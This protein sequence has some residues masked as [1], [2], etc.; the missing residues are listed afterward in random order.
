MEIHVQD[1][2]RRWLRA[3]L[4]LGAFVL[5]L[6]L[7]GQVATILV[8]FSDIL[9]VLLLAWLFAFMISPLVSLILRAAPRLPR[10]V[11]V[12]GIYVVLALLVVWITLTVAGSIANSVASLIALL[13]GDP[14][15]IQ[16]RLEELLAPLQ[17]LLTSLGFAITLPPPEEILQDL[18]AL[19]GEAA[20]PLTDFALFSVGL[21][22]NMLLVVFL[23]LFMLV[24]KD[25]IVAYLNRLVPPQWSD[26][27]L[28]FETSVASSFGGFIR[29]QVA[30]GVVMAGIAVIV[31][32]VFG[33]D[34]TPVSA[35]VTG[36]L[37]TIP[38]FGPAFAW[39]PP[40]VIA[41]L[42]KPDV[43]L[44]VTIAMLVGWFVVNNVL[45]P[46]L[47]ASAVGIHPVAVLVS[48]LIGLKVAGIAGAIFAVPFAAVA[49]AFFHH[50]LNRGAATRDVTSRAAQ[51]V[52]ER[53]GRRVR[54]PKPPMAAP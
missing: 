46:R 27:A 35:A 20:K 1:S 41:L 31:Q 43:V 30:Q 29:G 12:G 25:S 2:E 5:A 38:F 4:I 28:L 23:S 8:F 11:V 21:L 33:L 44:P 32:V 48:V 42:T 36:V 18:A 7:V 53:E 51:R 6:V 49:A 39:L 3:V 19:A 54:V 9:T 50:F 17:N 13:T 52:E 10:V 45:A 24:D 37:Q 40:V 15:V 22:A 26:E 47:M 34:F 16:G 14:E